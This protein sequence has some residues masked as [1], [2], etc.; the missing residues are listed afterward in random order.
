MESLEELDSPGKLLV[1]LELELQ[2]LSFEGLVL[3]SKDP[4][5][6]IC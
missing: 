3:L 5:L 6:E 2:V 4:T 1:L